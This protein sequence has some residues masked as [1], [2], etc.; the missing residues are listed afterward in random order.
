DGYRVRYK[1]VKREGTVSSSSDNYKFEEVSDLDTAN[2]SFSVDSGSVDLNGISYGLTE[3]GVPVSYKLEI[4]ETSGVHKYNFLD[5]DNSYLQSA[6]LSTVG[7]T[8]P[9]KIKIAYLNGCE[10][11]FKLEV[12]LVNIS[13]DKDIIFYTI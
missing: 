11:I 2:L 13:G 7:G 10:D 8:E 4:I 3:E 6:D 5:E 12:D 9:I 1:I